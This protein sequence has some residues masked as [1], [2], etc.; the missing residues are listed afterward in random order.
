MGEA[1]LEVVQLDAEG[2]APLEVVEEGVVGLFG[3][4]GVFLGEVHEVG[5]VRE[6]VAWC[7]CQLAR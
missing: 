2:F 4:V 7:V 1:L 6:D 5:A 3:S